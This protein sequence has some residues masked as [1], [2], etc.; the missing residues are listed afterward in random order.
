VNGSSS[1]FAV[2]TILGLRIL[3]T[4]ITSIGG[5]VPGFR[6]DGGAPKS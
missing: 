4:V 5:Q 3:G 6:Q 1:H 2:R